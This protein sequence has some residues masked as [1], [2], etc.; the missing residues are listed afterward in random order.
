VRW[1]HDEVL[2]GWIDSLSRDDEVVLQALV[3][4]TSPRNDA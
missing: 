3:D 4:S 2:G 1:R